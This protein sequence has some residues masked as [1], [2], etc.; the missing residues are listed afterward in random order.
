[1]KTHNEVELTTS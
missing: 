1:V